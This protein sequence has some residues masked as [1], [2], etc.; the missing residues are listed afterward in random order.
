MCAVR[1]TKNAIITSN[2]QLEHRHMSMHKN[3]IAHAAH[4]QDLYYTVSKRSRTVKKCTTPYDVCHIPVQQDAM[5]D[6]SRVEV[7]CCHAA[8]LLVGP[9][10][11]AICS[12]KHG[13]WAGTTDSLF[14][15]CASQCPCKSMQTYAK[16][17]CTIIY[18]H[19]HPYS[20]IYIG[21]DCLGNT[22]C[23][24]AVCRCLM[25]SATIPLA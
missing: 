13:W 4:K 7:S 23:I 19:I 16:H 21:R 18:T 9:K 8:M 14:E 6:R 24:V 3:I 15:I 12:I 2:I 25:S 1:H 17:T 20:R 5:S 11:P 10:N 22:L